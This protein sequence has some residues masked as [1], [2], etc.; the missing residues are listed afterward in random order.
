[1]EVTITTEI[2]KFLFPTDTDPKKTTALFLGKDNAAPNDDANFEIEFV[3]DE[4]ITINAEN[5]ATLSINVFDYVKF[6]TA[7]ARFIQIHYLSNLEKKL[8]I[9][10]RFQVTIGSTV[11][12]KM[13][14]LS[15]TNLEEFDSEILVDDF[16][17]PSE[18]LAYLFI[19]I[20]GK[21][22]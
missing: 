21:A 12:G 17:D 13:S 22:S 7:D 18:A 11:I 5:F 10:L 19:V 8:P 9:P 2:K 14:Q 4:C 20:G 1:M 15:L 16:Q 6:P 3:K